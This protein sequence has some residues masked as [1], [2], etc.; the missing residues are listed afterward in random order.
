MTNHIHALIQVSDIPLVR[1]MLHIAERYA[2][3][4]KATLHT[5][6]HLFE[7]RYYPVLVDADEYLLEL[8]WY[9]HLNP[10]RAH[11]VTSPDDFPCL[12]CFPGFPA[13]QRY[14]EGSLEVEGLSRRLPGCRL[15]RPNAA[16]EPEAHAQAEV[17][18][19][20]FDTGRLVYRNPAVMRLKL[21]Q[22][23]REPACEQAVIGRYVVRVL[24]R[25]GN[26][27]TEG[28]GP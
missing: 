22:F 7:K 8:L 6:G 9:I 27:D 5:T 12:M 25:S 15:R 21:D 1:L 28:E 26:L 13:R 4:F 11:M 24:Q 2:R 10:V 19:I 20:E 23:T 17:V 14:A 16:L 18:L 3:T